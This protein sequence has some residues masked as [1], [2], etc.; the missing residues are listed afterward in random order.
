MSTPATTTP[1]L[2][3]LIEEYRLARR[4]CAAL[5][6]GLDPEQIAGRPH[7]ESSAI[8]WHLG[9]QAAVAHYMMRNLTAAEPPIDAG[10]DR[11]FDSATP[12][13]ARGELPELERLHAYREEAA[14]RVE[15][16]VGRIRAGDVGAPHQLALVAAGMMRAIVN[17]EYQHGQWIREV[18]DSLTDAP[19]PRPA[20]TRLVVLDGYHVLR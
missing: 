10:L 1:S 14:V 5:V 15:A 7:E 6:E 16:T 2:D 3:E 13:R 18:R 11:L 8:G 12:E 19:C 17:H 9:H 20:S 4:W